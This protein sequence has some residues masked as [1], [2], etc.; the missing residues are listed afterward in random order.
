MATGNR[1]ALQ[2]PATLKGGADP[3]GP[4]AA[5]AAGT[6]GVPVALADGTGG[7][8]G[9]RE[10]QRVF[11]NGIALELTKALGERV[12]I[13]ASGHSSERIRSRGFP[14]MRRGPSPGSRGPPRAAE[15]WAQR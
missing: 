3:P 2:H 11:A 7:A 8:S 10:A 5:Q 6:C 9:I 15:D 13:D 1:P 4:T 12:E 14:L